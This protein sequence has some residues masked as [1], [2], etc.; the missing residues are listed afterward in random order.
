MLNL[1]LNIYIFFYNILVGIFYFK[2]HYVSGGEVGD[3]KSFFKEFIII[4]GG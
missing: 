3:N 2:T 4:R 1:I